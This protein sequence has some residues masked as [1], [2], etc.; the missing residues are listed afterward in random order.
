MENMF[1][2]SDLGQMTYFLGMEVFQ[3]ENGIFLGQKTFAAKILSK[4]SMENCKPVSTPV[5]VGTKLSSQVD[6]EKHFRA[7]KRVLRYIKG[8]LS[9]GLLYSK[10]DRLRLVGYTDSDWAGS[11]DDMK[12][13][14][15]QKRN[16][17]IFFTKALSLTRFLHLR[18][19]MGVCNMLAKE[20]S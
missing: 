2:M 4:F 8:T 17:R 11:K 5:V 10:T 1:E 16:W 15:V 19:E 13:T 14:S 3:T 18:A 12:S 20:E 6:N 7:A 9:Y